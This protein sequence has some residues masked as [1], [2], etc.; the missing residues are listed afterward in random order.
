[1]D[2]QLARAMYQEHILDHYKNPHNFGHLDKAT[3]RLRGNNPLCGD[4]LTLEF[5]IKN[6]VIEAVKFEG[7]GCAISMASASLLTDR[8]KGMK[9]AE[10]MQLRKEDILEM[11]QIP[12]GPVR[13]KCALLSLE[14]AQ[15]AIQ[16]K[17]K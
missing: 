7:V 15:K 5:V 2:E 6:E 17:E 13:L 9:V 10:A 11:L 3:H 14:T 8:L 4:D 16:S 12:I 1:M